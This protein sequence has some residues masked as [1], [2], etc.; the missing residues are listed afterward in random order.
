M[1]G[2]ERLETF[3]PERSNA[4]ERTIKNVHGTVMVRSR[5]RFENERMTV[6]N[7]YDQDCDIL[8]S[9]WPIFPKFDHKNTVF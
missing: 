8:S 6:V 4:L 3:E 7:I 5:S 1:D 2:Q 9:D